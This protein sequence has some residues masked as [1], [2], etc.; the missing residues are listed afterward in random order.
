MSDVDFARCST[1]S[2]VSEWQSSQGGRSRA[3]RPR[4]RRT[5]RFSRLFGLIDFRFAKASRAKARV[6]RPRPFIYRATAII[7][8]NAFS[9]WKAAA[10]FALAVQRYDV[11]VIAS[12]ADWTMTSRSEFRC[13]GRHATV[14]FAF[15]ARV[16]SLLS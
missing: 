10:H 6:R 1:E 12:S 5:K 16:L 9:L 4:R 13:G 11:S 7:L 15:Q 3:S 8:A 14:R 2:P